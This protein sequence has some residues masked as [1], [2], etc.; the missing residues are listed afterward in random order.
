MRQCKILRVSIVVQIVAAK[1]KRSYFYRLEGKYL[2]HNIRAPKSVSITSTLQ[3]RLLAS[4][5]NWYDP[6]ARFRE[7]VPVDGHRWI[8]RWILLYKVRDQIRCWCLIDVCF[9]GISTKWAT[10]NLSIVST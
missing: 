8:R 5:G 10:P 7:W 2:H 6:N 1:Q 4:L 3:D 9:E